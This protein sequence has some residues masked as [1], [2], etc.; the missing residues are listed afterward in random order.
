[1]DKAKLSIDTMPEQLVGLVFPSGAKLTLTFSDKELSPE[2]STHNK[3]LYISVECR[4]K[5]ESVVLVDI[6]LAINVCPSRT[7]Y[8][9]GLKPANFVPITQ[10]IRAYENTSREVM[11]T[12]QV[13]VQV[14]PAEQEGEFHV[15]D[16][17]ATFNLLLG[18]P[19][20]HHVKVASSTLHQMLKYPYEA[21]V[22]IVFRNSSIHS[23]PEVTTPM[24]EINHCDEDVFLLGF[25][26]AE[27]RVVQTILAVHEDMYASAQSI[28][29]MNKLQHVL[30]MGL[31][32]SG[33]KG[34]VALTDVLHNPHA[35]GL[36]YVPIKED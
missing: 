34:V 33:R 25:T 22:A 30:G 19:W 8:A 16:V 12:V 20:L 13:R 17:P 27:A 9:I 26:L 4:E 31:R 32:R 24:L 35:F 7:A 21:G 18:R 3:P 14:G 23:P 11:G 5:W 6:G 1:M 15:L 28:Y 10:V 2:G 36:G 29:F